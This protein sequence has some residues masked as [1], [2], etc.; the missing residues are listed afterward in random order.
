MT[1]TLILCKSLVD[2]GEALKKDC[3]KNDCV[4]YRN[5]Y[6]RYCEEYAD[7][8]RIKTA[9][10]DLSEATVRALEHAIRTSE[11]E[12]YGMWFD[13]YA[14]LKQRAALGMACESTPK[15]KADRGGATVFEAITKDAATLAAL[16]GSLPE[17][18]ELAADVLTR[19]HAERDGEENVGRVLPPEYCFFTGDGKH[20]HFTIGWQDTET[21]GWTLESPYED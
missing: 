1:D 3:P 13:N 5:I 12:L 9:I 18:E 4:V 7:Y 20:N 2:F 8:Q 11:K 10:P 16:L 6:E 14:V 19:Y 17:L 21:W 15:P